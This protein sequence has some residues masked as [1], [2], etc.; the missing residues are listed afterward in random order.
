[1]KGKKDFTLITGEDS[2]NGDSGGPLIKIDSKNEYEL[3]AISSNGYYGV[4]VGCTGQQTFVRVSM[5]L[6]WIQKNMEEFT[7]PSYDYYLD[8][9]T[10]V[11]IHEASAYIKP[12]CWLVLWLLFICN[13]LLELLQYTVLLIG[14]LLLI[15]SAWNLA[16]LPSDKLQ[17][18]INDIKNKKKTMRRLLESDKN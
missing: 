8:Y 11:M 4:L 13:V 17:E 12:I 3:I 16:M 14:S 5:Y 2:C 7:D 1:M 6:D 15:K 18:A 10:V 9:E